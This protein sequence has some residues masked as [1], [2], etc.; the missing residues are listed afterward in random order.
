MT[1]DRAALRSIERDEAI[2]RLFILPAFASRKVAAI[3]PADDARLHRDLAARP[4]QANPSSPIEDPVEVS[5]L[6]PASSL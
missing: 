1:A 5:L 6:A 3:C 4:V 2:L